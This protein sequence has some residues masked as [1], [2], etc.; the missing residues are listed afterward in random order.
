MGDEPDW[1]DDYRDVTITVVEDFEADTV[2][3]VIRR[4]RRKKTVEHVMPAD[5]YDDLWQAVRSSEMKTRFAVIDEMAA[6]IK[7]LGKKMQEE[8]DE[9]AKDWDEDPSPRKDP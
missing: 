3:L 8:A 4:A 5:V 7:E 2:K 6:A 1:V 9:L